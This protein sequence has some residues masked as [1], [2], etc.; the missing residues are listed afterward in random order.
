M[1]A[2]CSR[3]VAVQVLTNITG[4]KSHTDP[5]DALVAAGATCYTSTSPFPLADRMIT[6]DTAVTIVGPVYWSPHALQVGQWIAK[7]Q[8]STVAGS[9]AAH[10][11]ALAAAATPYPPSMARPRTPACPTGQCPFAIQPNPA[12]PIQCWFSPLGGAEE[13]IQTA[14]LAARSTI[15][16]QV[17]TATNVGIFQALIAARRQGVD[18]QIVADEYCATLAGSQITN[19]ARSGIP[20][21]LDGTEKIMHDKVL[22]IDGRTTFTGSYNFSDPAEKKNSENLIRID[23]PAIATAFTANWTKHQA[24][25]N[26]MHTTEATADV[27]I[28][29]SPPPTHARAHRPRLIHLFRIWRAYH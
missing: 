19:A 23:D 14:A 27:S 10:F 20:V 2:A 24:H 29:P 15:R 17:Y 1:V 7:I 16:A 26:R 11:A 5:L 8:S 25:S 13:A 4:G 18:V 22:I 6:T 28:N 21:Y 3:S 9:Y 12:L